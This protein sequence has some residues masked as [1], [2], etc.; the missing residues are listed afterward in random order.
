MLEKIDADIK[1]GL[2]RVKRAFEILGLDPSKYRTILVAGTNGKGTTSFYLERTLRK[3]GFRTALF[4]SPH[5]TSVGER[6]V[7]N[8]KPV[9]ER[10]LLE[11]W[12][13]VKRISSRCSLE[14]TPFESFFVS[15][16]MRVCEGDYDFFVCEVGLGGRLDATNVLDAELCVITGIALDHTRFLG[17]TLESVAREKAGI[18]K[19]GAH[20][21][22]GSMPDEARKVILDAAEDKAETVSVFGEDFGFSLRSR[23][24]DG[25]LFDYRGDGVW[26]CLFLPTGFL[27]FVHNAVLALRA[28]EFLCRLNRKPLERALDAVLPGRGEL[29]SVSGKKVLLDVAHNPHALKALLEDLR[30]L[31]TGKMVIF[32]SPLE[33]KDYRSMIE[34]AE[35]YGRLYLVRQPTERGVK[36]WCAGDKVW[37]SFDEAVERLK[38]DDG[39]FVFTG[40]FWIVRR[41]KEF[42]EN[43]LLYRD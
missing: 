26:E 6:L 31:Y 23:S 41:F 7:L 20:L 37:L 29:V 4:T 35:R 18:I 32:L 24:L 28:S 25:T 36:D 10:L 14:L 40:S 12:E 33:D 11:G 15:A 39:L 1:L 38:R 16:Y 21:V 27:S 22:L 17:N 8:G 13:Y 34:L 2:D 30:S 3:H 42:L 9:D 5:L 43:C 19:R